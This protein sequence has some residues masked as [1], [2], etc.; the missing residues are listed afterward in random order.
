MSASEA[1][2]IGAWTSSDRAVGTPVRRRPRAKAPACGR[3]SLVGGG[4]TE[5]G[6][7]ERRLLRLRW[8]PGLR[9]LFEA[10]RPARTL[11]LLSGALTVADPIHL[12]VGE[13]SAAV[14]KTSA[15]RLTL[16]EV[17]ALG[18]DRYVVD[19]IVSALGDE[20]GPDEITRLEGYATAGRGGALRV[21]LSG[22]AP[23]ALE[24]PDEG[25]RNA[26][27]SGRLRTRGTQLQLTAVF[28]H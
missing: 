8:L 25:N 27:A 17:V 5:I 4:L 26:A 19:L 6:A 7:G 23:R 22:P 21:V 20:A 9:R 1:Y 13:V 18:N 28:E 12:T 3:W 10:R 24:W 11:P 2:G 15:V 16:A 14:G